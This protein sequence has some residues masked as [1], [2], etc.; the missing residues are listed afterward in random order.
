MLKP[1]S[2]LV[3]TVLSVLTGCQSLRIDDLATAEAVDPRETAGSLRRADTLTGARAH[4]KARNYGKAYAL[5][6]QAAETSRQDPAAWLGLAASADQLG[7]FDTADIAYGEVARLLPN[8][9][10]YF[11]NIGYSNML[12]GNLTKARQ[13]FVAAQTISPNNAVVA[14]NLQLLRN[15]TMTGA[16]T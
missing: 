12:R 14:N 5:F 8:R 2:I 6:K 15:S 11:N 4:F 3:L 1:A 10:E 9:V 7:R 13:Y 16:R